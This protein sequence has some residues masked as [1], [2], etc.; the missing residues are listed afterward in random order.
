MYQAVEFS[1]NGLI[2]GAGV[3]LLKTKLN[4]TFFDVVDQL[5][6]INKAQWTANEIKVIK[7]HQIKNLEGKK[8]RL[9]SY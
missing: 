2:S 3:V 1:L 6:L 5:E 9:L 8:L 7:L 4:M